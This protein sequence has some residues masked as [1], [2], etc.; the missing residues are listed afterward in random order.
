MLI[1]VLCLALLNAFYYFNTPSNA[2][3]WQSQYEHIPKIEF[4]EST[5]VIHNFRRARYDTN[6]QPATINWSQ[7]SVDINQLESVWFGISVFASPGLAHT[8]LSFDFGDKDPVVISIEARMRPE[9]TYSPTKGALDQYHL[10]YVIADEQDII[11]VR[12]HKRLESVYFMPLKVTK[13]RAQKMFLD[14]LK[15]ANKL[16]QTPEFYNTF[17]SN[18]TNSIMKH[19]NLSAWQ[20]YLDPRIVLSGYSDKIA[21]E[22][23]LIENEY[24]LEIIREAALIQ[25]D[26]FAADDVNFYRLIRENYFQRLKARVRQYQLKS[27]SE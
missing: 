10:A 22:Y 14:M 27:K 6:G 20:Y 26:S 16:N 13:K 8:F 25:A 4:A 1:F 9:Q 23:E 18:C 11:G 3:L 19:T 12:T 5:G 17:T 24:P 7:R 21:Y 2:G 15:T